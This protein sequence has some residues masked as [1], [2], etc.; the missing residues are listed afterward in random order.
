MNPLET[1]AEK[2]AVFND[3]CAAEL[4]TDELHVWEL[5][6]ELYRLSCGKDLDTSWRYEG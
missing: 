4:H 5:L 1:I 2:I 3:N 6:T